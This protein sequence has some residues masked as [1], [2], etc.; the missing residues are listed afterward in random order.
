MN[1]PI[2]AGAGGNYINRGSY[3]TYISKIRNKNTSRGN[4]KPS[5][6]STNSKKTS[7]I[8]KVALSARELKNAR[9]RGVN[10]AKQNPHL[11]SVANNVIPSRGGTAG[12]VKK[13]HPEGTQKGSSGKTIDREKSQ[14]DHLDGNTD[15]PY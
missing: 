15:V 3:A 9:Q 14:S 13:Y 6:K 10:R 8:K 5:P 7:G 11:A 4:I 12:H 1:S 2:A